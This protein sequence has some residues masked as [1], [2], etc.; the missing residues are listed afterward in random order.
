MPA[1]QNNEN[2]W[3]L[4]KKV[5][6][7]L[8]V[9]ILVQT[10]AAGV[11]I[12]RMDSRITQLEVNEQALA[13]ERKERRSNVEAR[14]GLLFEERN[15]LVRLETDLGYIKEALREIRGALTSTERAGPK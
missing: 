15:R 5:P 12:S 6:I 14:I 8:I 7:T 11:A 3:H 4:D 10:F 13:I 1:E 2:E 9:A